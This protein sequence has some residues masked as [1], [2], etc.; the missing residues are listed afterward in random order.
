MGLLTPEDLPIGKLP[1]QTQ[2]VQAQIYSTHAIA[3]ARSRRNGGEKKKKKKKR[4][5]SRHPPPHPGRPSA[6]S[7]VYPLHNTLTLAQPH[8]RV[9]E[10][11]HNPHP[12][13][14]KHIHQLHLLLLT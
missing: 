10:R 4:F 5:T 9:Q 3:T 2:S 1:I 13:R 11:I 6:S 8:R 7:P 12:L 14:L